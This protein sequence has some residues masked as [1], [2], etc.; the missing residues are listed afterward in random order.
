MGHLGRWGSAALPR[1]SRDAVVQ[2]R[3]IA[4]LDQRNPLTVLRAPRGFGKTTSISRWLAGPT[5]DVETV[6]CALDEG[7]RLSAGFWSRLGEALAPVGT[8]DSGPRGDWD[9]DSVVT[10]L[11]QHATPLRL[12][13][14]NFHE[15]GHLDGADT[16]DHDLLEVVRGNDLLELV[17]STRALRSLETTGALSVDTA[18]VRPHDFALQAESVLELAQAR[19]VRM[20]EEDANRLVHEL[21]G[22][23]AAIRACVDA[24]SVSDDDATADGHLV[25]GFIE[26]LLRDLRSQDLREFLM[27]TA[28]PV[29]FSAAA[30]SAMVPGSNAVRDLRNLLVSGILQE[31]TTIA[32]VRYA[33]PPAMRESIARYV[34]VHR[35]EVI[36]EVN[37][38]LMAVA[39]YEGGPIDV[40]RH[41]VHAEEWEVALRVLREEWGLLTAQHQ[42]QLTELSR[43]FPPEL[44]A[45]EPRLSV[46]TQV[47]PAMPSTGKSGLVWQPTSPS[48]LEETNRLRTADDVVPA[49]VGLLMFQTGTAAV[50]AGENDVAT[51]AFGKV[52]GYGVANDDED[53]RLMGMIG[54]LMVNAIAGEVDR[55]LELAADPTVAEVLD[56][57]PTRGLGELMGI[58]GRIAVAIAA[59]DG[60][61]T[62]ASGAVSRIV[63]PRRR[64]ELWALAVNARA[65]HATTSPSPEVRD[66]SAGQLRAA[67]RHL[68]PGGITE[69]TLGTTLVELLLLAKQ[70]GVAE[71]VLDRLAPSHVSQPTRALLYLAQGRLAEAVTTAEESLADP[72]LTVR[73]QHLCETTIASSL[74][75]QGQVTAARRNFLQAVQLSRASGQRRGFFLMSTEVFTALSADDPAILAL[76]GSPRRWRGQDA[77]WSL[78]DS[79]MTD[80]DPGYSH[81]GLPRTARPDRRPWLDGPRNGHG[82]TMVLDHA[83]GGA[84]E[85][86]VEQL[87]P[88]EIEVLVALRDSLGPAGVA[89]VLGVSVNTAKTH[90]RNVY[91]KLGASG[92]SE[93][94]RLA[95]PFLREPG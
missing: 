10:L 32:G 8:D 53:A 29:E 73:S 38:A 40:L 22:W 20:T 87:S 56:D 78:D 86:N 54:L 71:Q 33:Y 14:D 44:R 88:R 77:S 13:I 3:V 15:A 24:A 7:S 81:T 69:A 68:E 62:A 59:S 80:I 75:L 17:V 61:T 93:A 52:R 74:Y 12:V 51:Y 72:R 90:V 36:A 9:R 49:D 70:V 27:R 19:N 31:R 82:L 91:R 34:S 2:R 47:L 42:R 89:Q 63:E 5:P 35:P 84:G 64:D 48:F 58:A 55:A 21:G 4:A 79:A 28:V 60:V 50:F 25:D 6:Y 76:R 65:L 67:M 37:R 95:V 46:M 94:L 66:G 18:V 83:P 23:P 45:S 11:E 30:A 57:V 16:I 26:T 43:L 41:A 92:R 39:A 1:A 85:R